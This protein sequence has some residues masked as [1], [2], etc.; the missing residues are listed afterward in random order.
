MKK[1]ILFKTVI[2]LFAFIF[3]LL[4]FS[5]KQQDVSKEFKPI[6]HAFNESWNTGDLDALDA[7]VDP[8]YIK[9]T[10]DGPQEGLDLLKQMISS[11]R[12]AFPDYH[13][14]YDEEIYVGDK[15]VVRWTVT[16]TNTGPGFGPPTGKKVKITGITIFR[17]VDSKIVEDLAE[18][19]GLGLYQQLGYTLAPPSLEEEE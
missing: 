18:S 6:I 15:A 3:M 17:F 7:V 16:G 19:D 1:S 10:A 13:C 2:P 8:K 5:C 9:H 4:T 14:T 12:I 11:N